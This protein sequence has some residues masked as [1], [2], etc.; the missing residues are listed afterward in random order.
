MRQ[1]LFVYD[2]SNRPSHQLREMIGERRFGE[3]LFKRKSL[4][5]RC[6]EAVRRCEV[7]QH[8]ETLFNIEDVPLLKGKLESLPETAI[9]HLFSSYIIA[10]KVQGG[11]FSICRFSLM[12]APSPSHASV[13]RH[14]VGVC[15]A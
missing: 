10:V 8:F 13:P 11:V 15:C 4:L 1:V 5:D 9:V 7:I 6:A 14:P 2:D 12:P 3:V